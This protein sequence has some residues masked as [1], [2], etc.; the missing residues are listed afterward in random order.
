VFGMGTG[1]TP[2]AKSP[3]NQ[4]S[5]TSGRYNKPIVADKTNLK[6]NSRTKLESRSFAYAQD[7]SASLYRFLTV[8]A[9][10]ARC[11]RAQ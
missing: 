10:I 11:R 7:D 1:V 6:L 8:A 4:L 5:L 3:R 9:R 2:P